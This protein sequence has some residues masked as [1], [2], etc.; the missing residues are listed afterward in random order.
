MQK[1]SRNGGVS[2]D[3]VDVE[4]EKSETD[5][6]IPSPESFTAPKTSFAFGSFRLEAILAVLFYLLIGPTLILLNKHI[7]SDL[8]F[9]FPVTLPTLGLFTSS[10][11]SRFLVKFK[12]VKLTKEVSW[13]DYIFKIAPI[14]LFMALTLYLGNRSYLYLSVSLIQLL[15]SITP[16]FT[17]LLLVLFDFEDPNFKIWL[18]IVLICIGTVTGTAETNTPEWSI[19]GLVIMVLSCMA[20]AMRMLTMQILLQGEKYPAIESLYYFAPVSFFWMLLLVAYLELSDL[21]SDGILIIWLHPYYFIIASILGFFVNIASVLVVKTTSS[22]TLKVLGAVRNLGLVGVAVMFF[23][24]I[25]SK[26]EF[27]GYVVS[28]SGILMYNYEKIQQRKPSP[29]VASAILSP[30][31]S[32]SASVQRV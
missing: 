14:G 4:S 15:K 17:L 18:A 32:S 23:D 28:V 26:Q 8:G 16:V 9:K 2:L 13:R 11:I 3:A 19:L 25:V 29:S 5:Q 10:V 20:E 22:L 12:F 6:F 1:Y 7:Y 21:L 31:S 30:I 24:D 27:F